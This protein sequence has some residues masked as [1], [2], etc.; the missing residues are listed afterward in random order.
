[1]KAHHAVP[2]A[3]AAGCL[4]LVTATRATSAERPWAQDRGFTVGL[5]YQADVIGAEDPAPGGDPNALFV[6]EVGHGLALNL[7]YTFT[8]NFALRLAMGS[9]IHGTN[10]E[11]VE[12]TRGSAVLEAQVRFLPGE[13]ARPYLVGGLGG[14]RLVDDRE[15]YD[16]E[17]SGGVGVLGGGVFYN[18]TEHLALEFSGRL[19]MI[20]W[21]EIKFRKEMP[22]GADIELENPIDENGSAGVFRLGFDLQF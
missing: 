3:F 2:I 18:L 4:C 11:G 13:R 16:V 19:E 8:P 14:T 21:T 10:W 7:G 20:N 6:E 1:M 15:G 12:I 9:A 5:Q 22:G 17:T